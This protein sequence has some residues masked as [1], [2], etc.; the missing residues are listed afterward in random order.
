LFPVCPELKYAG[1][2]NPLN[3][4]HHLKPTEWSK[5]REGVVINRPVKPGKG[6]W[7]NVGFQ[8]DV[9]VDLLIEEGTFFSK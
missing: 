5:Y 6:S 4:P 7:V 8:K 1:L 2:M 9:Q 3:T